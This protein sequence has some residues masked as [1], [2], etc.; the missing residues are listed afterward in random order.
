M[1]FFQ[2]LEL[3]AS[4]SE[5]LYNTGSDDYA[6]KVGFV[7]YTDKVDIISTNNHEK[8]PIRSILKKESCYPKDKTVEDSY[9]IPIAEKGHL[10][11]FTYNRHGNVI[12]IRGSP[13]FHDQW[14]LVKAEGAVARHLKNREL[15][16]SQQVEARRQKLD[17]NE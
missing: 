11:H 12:P 17:M 9:P 1:D 14:F 15:K 16:R 8:Y 13:W 5:D 6:D 4:V 10:K 2:E 3:L 7:L